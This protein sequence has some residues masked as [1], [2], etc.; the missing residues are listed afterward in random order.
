MVQ[1]F[2][3]QAHVYVS[4]LEINQCTKSTEIQLFLTL[5]GTNM[6]ACYQLTQDEYNLGCNEVTLEYS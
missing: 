5:H 3:I 1:K 2:E 6:Q 4:I